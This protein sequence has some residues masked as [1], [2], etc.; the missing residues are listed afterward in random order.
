MGDGITYLYLS[1]DDYDER[2]WKNVNRYR[3]PG[4]TVSN[5]ERIEENIASEDTLTDC[6]YVGGLAD[7]KC[8]VAAMKFK[9]STDAM[10]FISDLEGNKA[11][12]VFEDYIVCAGNFIKS[13]DH[14]S[15]ETVML[16]RINKSNIKIEDH[17]G[18][19]FIPNYGGI[20]IL[21]DRMQYNIEQNNGFDEIYA[22]H[23]ENPMDASY[24]CV[25]TA[26]WGASDLENIKSDIQIIHNDDSVTSVEDTGLGIISYVFW[27]TGN[28]GN[29]TVTDPCIVMIT[30]DKIT[31]CDPTMKLQ[32]I[33][34]SI[35]E[36]EYRFSGLKNGLS[37][38]VYR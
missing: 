18:S 33:I 32:E 3:I 4:T 29:I 34:V 36:K 26:R 11:W 9:A 13:T 15:I 37:Q 19:I 8:S 5:I 21:D 28:C 30:E 31:I 22:T 6:D 38:S 20:V 12:F 17:D 27:E 24:I 23:G 25:N 10:D 35:G 16:N 14:S 7:G 2:Y 1:P